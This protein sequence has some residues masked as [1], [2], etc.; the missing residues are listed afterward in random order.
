MTNIVKYSFN[1]QNIDDD[2][3]IIS[4]VDY[5]FQTTYTLE[6]KGTL[7]IGTGT[8]YTAINFNGMTAVTSVRINT[9]QSINMKINSG[10]EVFVVNKDLLWDGTCSALSINNPSTTATATVYYEL[11]Q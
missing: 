7:S 1:E 8:S 3:N 10:T 6:Q 4:E 2:E 5:D 11:Y 9:D